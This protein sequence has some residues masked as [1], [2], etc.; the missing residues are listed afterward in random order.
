VGVPFFFGDP[1]R[2][3]RKI[4]GVLRILRRKG[5][6]GEGWLI[7]ERKRRFPVKGGGVTR[8]RRWLEGG[9]GRKRREGGGG[10]GEGGR[11]RRGRD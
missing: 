7:H 10:G 3:D 11:G 5:R 1:R 9:K 2:G 4:K 6:G 8:G